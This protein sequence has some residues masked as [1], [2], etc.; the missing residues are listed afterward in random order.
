MDAVDFVKLLVWGWFVQP[1]A[2]LNQL[3]AFGSQLDQTITARR[4]GKTCSAAHLALQ[5]WDLYLTN[6]PTE[7]TS[8]D[9]CNLCKLRWQI[10]LSFRMWKSQLRL[11]YVAA[12]R[13]ERVLCQLYAHLIGCVL[14]HALTAD[15]R[16]HEDIEYSPVK[17]LQRYFLTLWSEAVSPL[18]FCLQDAFKRFARRDKRKKA[19][20]TFSVF[21]RFNSPLYYEV[22]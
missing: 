20:S 22:L 17:L 8:Q 1:K 16:C 14:A 7:W 4:D 13:I 18:T 5:S 3:A 12:W 21:G 9:I 15:W 11:T 6:L 10:E 2:S 19:P